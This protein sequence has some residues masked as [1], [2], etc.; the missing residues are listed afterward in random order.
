[1]ADYWKTLNDGEEGNQKGT[2][3]R[4]VGTPVS[5]VVMELLIQVQFLA[6][7]PKHHTFQ[8]L[9][10]AISRRRQII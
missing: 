5:A 7:F 3:E 8:G 1:M 10:S 6:A 9:A 4:P 2:K